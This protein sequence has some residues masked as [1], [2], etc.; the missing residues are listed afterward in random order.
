MAPY[1][2]DFQKTWVYSRPDE[3]KASS[4]VW[5]QKQ[6]MLIHNECMKDAGYL[7]GDGCLEAVCFHDLNW[8]DE[9]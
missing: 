3:S 1:S 5:I 2:S 7:S 6:A 8:G 9:E 4:W